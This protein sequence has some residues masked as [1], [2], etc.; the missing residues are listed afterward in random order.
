M[1][2]NKL[3]WT[4]TCPKCGK[5]NPSWRSRC[6]QCGEDLHKNEVELPKFKRRGCGFGIAF[7]SGVVG[8]LILSFLSVLV[9]GWS[10]RFYFSIGFLVILAPPVLGLVLCWKWPRIAGVLL[11]VGGIL[12]PVR[13]IIA[14]GFTS[15][16]VY[17]IPI[18]LPLVISGV[19]FIRMKA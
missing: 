17:F 18:I 4:I 6:E 15:D 11:I 19:M 12:L 16:L 5:E 2:D 9:M 14:V 3:E 13:M 8:L 1:A 10:G 7:I